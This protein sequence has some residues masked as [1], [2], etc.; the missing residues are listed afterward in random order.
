MHTKYLGHMAKMTAT[1]IYGKKPLKSSSPDPDKGWPWDLLCS[2]GEVRPTKFV[3]IMI[4]DWPW[5]AKRQGQILLHN[6]FNGLFLK[7]FF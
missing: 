1:T 6:A 2:I 7:S 3:Q 5:P 4:L